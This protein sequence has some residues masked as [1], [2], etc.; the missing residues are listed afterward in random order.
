MPSRRASVPVRKRSDE[1]SAPRHRIEHMFG[2]YV[3][4]WAASVS[5]WASSSFRVVPSPR[6]LALDGPAGPDGGVA[7]RRSSS[8][9]GVHAYHTK[10]PA[11]AITGFIREHTNVGDVVLD[12]FCGSGMTGVA[13]SMLARNA[14]LNDLSPAASHIA[15]NYTTPCDPREFD[16][17]V[18]RVLTEVGEEV[19]ALYATTHDGG[20]AQI[21]YLVWSDVRCC[22]QCGAELVLWN[23]RETGL[24]MIR[25]SACGNDAPKAELRVIGERAVEA[26][27][28]VAGGKRRVAR[29]VIAGDLRPDLPRESLPWYPTIVFDTSRPMWRRGHED[30][31]IRTVADFY[32]ARNLTAFSR[33]WDAASRE[34]DDRLRSALRFSLTAIANRASR[35]Y[36]WNAKRPTNVLGGTLYISSLRYEWNVLSLWR[37]KTRAVS[38]LFASGVATPDA[39]TV[40]QSS[41]TRLPLPD[42]SIDYCFTDP[43]F[44]AHI[45]YS[46][47]SLLWEAWLDDLTDRSS[48]AIVV[49]GGSQA[50]SVSDYGELLQAAFSEVRR[51]LKPQGRA[52]VVF[53]SSDPETWSAVYEAAVDAGLSFIDATTLNKG[54][55]SF[56]QVKGQRSGEMVAETD[57]V[58]TFSRQPAARTATPLIDLEEA[59]RSA[60]KAAVDGRG[61]VSAGAIFAD[62]NAR[63]LRGSARPVGIREVHDVLIQ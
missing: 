10:I 55:P 23:H 47:V 35:R 59:V 14:I 26:S 6:Q 30:L 27:L 25:C 61:G 22:G 21:E 24:R 38:K 43:P 4:A 11:E 13:A 34:A 36:Q 18:A 48:E 51:V 56:K 54:Q 46:D 52:T 42:E 16:A 49:R 58:L 53:Q 2:T 15:A 19:A 62:V 28:S 3:S 57:V 8:L 31:G 5:A 12:P 20:E 39:V 45:V 17:A 32:S 33:L 1:P 44:G 29:E 63:L 7:V 9:Y 50:K 37:R 40:L 60:S 41:A